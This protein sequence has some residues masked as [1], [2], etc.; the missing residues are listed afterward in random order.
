[1]NDTAFRVLQWAAWQLFVFFLAFL[2]YANLFSEY[3]IYDTPAANNW[4]LV[5][6]FVAALFVGTW[7]PVR[8]WRRG[9]HP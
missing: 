3:G 1:M 5:A 2:V 7:I 6:C 9:R 8:R 4:G